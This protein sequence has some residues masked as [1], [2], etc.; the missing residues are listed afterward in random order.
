MSDAS[1]KVAAPPADETA[2]RVLVALSVAHLLNDTLQAL[3]PAFYPLLKD[4][5][6]LT[7]AQIGLITFTYQLTGSLLQPLIGG[8]TDRRAL[9]R[10]LAGG[11]GVWPRWS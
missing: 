2:M 9:P 5:Y 8:T 6:R 1:A 11:R 7:F 3:I 10:S 4:N